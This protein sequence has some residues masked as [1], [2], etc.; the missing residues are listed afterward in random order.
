[1]AAVGAGMLLFHRVRFSG[2]ARL[3]MAANIVGNGML[4]SRA[5]LEAHPWD[6][7]TGAEDLEYSMHFAL[8]GVRPRFAPAARVAGPGAATRQGAVRQRLRWEGGRFY[9][10]RAWIGK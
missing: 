6:A 7:F 5:V 9:V 4:F 10:A 1:S 8:A 3:G 2:R